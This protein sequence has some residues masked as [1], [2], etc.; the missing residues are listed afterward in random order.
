[1]QVHEHSHC[2]PDSDDESSSLSYGDDDGDGN[3]NKLWINSLSDR[4]PSNDHND[5]DYPNEV[6][7]QA[8]TSVSVNIPS[9]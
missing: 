6:K 2:H 4:L 7:C 1:M 9:C 5:D 8:S 3:G